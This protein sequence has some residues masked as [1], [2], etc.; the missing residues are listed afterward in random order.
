MK[1]RSRAAG[2][3]QAEARSRTAS[4]LK[5]NNAPKAAAHRSSATQQVAEWLET[6]GLGQY[7]QHFAENDITFAILSDLTDQDLKNLELPRSVTG[8]SYC[9][10]SQWTKRVPEPIS[11]ASVAQRYRRAPPGH[12]DVLV[13]SSVD[14]TFGPYG[15]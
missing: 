10:P 6:L 1:K 4:K 2:S 12:G 14:R 9:E 8:V 3:K 5:R 13:T 11:C 15:P 7:A